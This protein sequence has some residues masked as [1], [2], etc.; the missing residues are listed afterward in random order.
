MLIRINS[1]KSSDLSSATPP[2][3]LLAEESGSRHWYRSCTEHYDQGFTVAPARVV[4]PRTG[5]L[6]EDRTAWLYAAA[7]VDS[8]VVLHVALSEHRGRDS[9]ETFLE[10]LQETP[11]S[12]KSSPWLGFRLPELGS[13]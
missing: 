12:P 6:G 4:L 10:E 3:L 1:G 13:I 7:D 9:V 11:A 8:Q 2:G 5:P